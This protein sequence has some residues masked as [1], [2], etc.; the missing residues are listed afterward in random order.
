V[1]AVIAAGSIAL[2]GISR[3][4]AEH[5]CPEPKPRSGGSR[6]LARAFAERD[7]VP[8][9]SLYYEDDSHR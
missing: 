4:I 9:E 5:G 1:D 2:T 3:D 6:S 8:I 7:V